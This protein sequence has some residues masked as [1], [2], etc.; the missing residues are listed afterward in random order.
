MPIF[1]Q[2]RSE[3]VRKA[4]RVI[5]PQWR[6][7]ES[8]LLDGQSGMTIKKFKERPDLPVAQSHAEL[9]TMIADRL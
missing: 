3:E 9:Q 4:L 7:S 8:D 2:T 6:A 5:S 1:L